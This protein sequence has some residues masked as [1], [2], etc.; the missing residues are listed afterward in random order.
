[1]NGILYGARSWLLVAMKTHAFFHCRK[2][3]SFDWLCT[4]VLCPTTGFGVTADCSK[5]P[6]KPSLS[7]VGC[8]GGDGFCDFSPCAKSEKPLFF[9]S[10]CTPRPTSI[11]LHQHVHKGKRSKN[12]LVGTKTTPPKLTKEADFRSDS[13]PSIALPMRQA[14]GMPINPLGKSVTP[15]RRPRAV[16]TCQ[17]KAMVP[18]CR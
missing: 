15:E 3:S 18:H 6:E 16:T 12:L 13:P 8:S 9:R 14:S 17:P 10:P 4:P 5:H 11:F 2:R 1:M 7:V